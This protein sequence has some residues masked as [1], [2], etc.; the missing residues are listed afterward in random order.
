[1]G[2]EDIVVLNNHI[3]ALVVEVNAV[4][5]AAVDPVAPYYPSA[6]FKTYRVPAGAVYVVVFQGHRTVVHAHRVGAADNLETAHYRPCIISPA[7]GA[8]DLSVDNCRVLPGVRSVIT[9]GRDN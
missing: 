3:F 5:A 4:V 1:M 2:I 6:A 8:G 7:A 9:F